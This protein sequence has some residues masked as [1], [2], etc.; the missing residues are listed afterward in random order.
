MIYLG[1]KAKEREYGDKQD[2]KKGLKT[3]IAISFVYA[4]RR[5]CFSW[6]WSRLSERVGCDRPRNRHRANGLVLAQAFAGLFVGALFLGLI[7]S[8]VIS[9]FLAKVRAIVATNLRHEDDLADVLALFEVTMGGAGFVEGEG[10]VDVGIDPTFFH[11]AQQVAHPDGHLLRF[12]PHVTQ[13]QSKHTAVLVQQRKRMKTR[14]L[15]RRFQHI[16][17]P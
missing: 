6:W 13:V 3:G 1:L 7:Y 11:T 12:V 8:T 2:F 10:A 9:F 17:L 15:D 5:R 16:E 4:L 14:R